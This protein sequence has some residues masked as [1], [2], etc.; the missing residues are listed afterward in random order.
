MALTLV[1]AGLPRTGTSSLRRALELLLGGR[2]L[3]MS[4]LRG[5]PFDLGAVWDR[6]L[7]GKPVDWTATLVSYVATVDW[8][9]AAFWRDIAAAHP[10]AKVLLSLRDGPRTWLQSMEAT[11]LP[12]ARMASQPEWTGCRGLVKLLEQFTGAVDW[13][14]PEILIAAYQR[15]VRAVR[16]EVPTE[17]LVEWHPGDGWGPLCDALDAPRPREQF[18]W[19]N[20][21]EDWG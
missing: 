5:H 9:A 11:V 14:S 10:R 15:Q 3:H 17:R 7:E 21:R 4:A 20:R 16:A 1:G 6:A 2:C 13:D 12:V 18:P 8:P 19:L